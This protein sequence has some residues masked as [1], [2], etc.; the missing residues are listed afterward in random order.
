MPAL[1]LDTAGPYV[2]G[3]FLVFLLLVLVYVGIMA[4]KLARIERELGELTEQ[5]AARREASRE[6]ELA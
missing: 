1:P 2:A 5:V 4:S 3:A 6:K